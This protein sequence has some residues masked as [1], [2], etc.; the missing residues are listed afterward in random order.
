MTKECNHRAVL[1][2]RTGRYY[3]DKEIRCAECNHHLHPDELS[4]YNP[5]SA[6]IKKEG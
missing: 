1:Q 5:I 2:I 3:S 6:H 4:G